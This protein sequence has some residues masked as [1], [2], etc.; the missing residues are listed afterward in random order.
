MP[1]PAAGDV[2][3]GR[4]APVIRPL[5][6]AGR[7]LLRQQRA[8]AGGPHRRH[9]RQRHGE[10]LRGE[11]RR[12]ARVHATTTAR[13]ARSDSASEVCAKDT[14]SAPASAATVRATRVTLCSPRALKPPA[15]NFDAS[16]AP[17]SGAS[18]N[19]PA[20]SIPAARAP[21]TRRATAAED[22][23]GAPA[24][25]SSG[26]GR[27]ERHHQIEAVEQ[28][29][30]D[31]AP[32]AGAGDRAAGAG[33]LVDAFPAWARVH[34][35]DQEERRGKGHGA[36]GAAHPDDPLLEWLA[37]RLQCGH[38][39]LTEFVEEQDA[40]R[41]QAHLTGTERPAP[42]AHQGDDGGLVVRRTEGRA[43]AAARPRAGRS[44][45]QSEYGSP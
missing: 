9:G 32:V 25:S 26:S 11:V 35:G 43:L 16:S 8:Q 13:P 6:C 10:R 27:A 14:T 28:R 2:A 20:R 4:T 1:L 38:G 31:A 22:S 40:V 30:R 33:T 45:R 17:A 37:Q 18:S 34:G 24:R 12:I 44:R 39:E 5:P 19:S 42:P 21:A 3:H 29:R 36:A 41:G 15:R 7:R 23:P